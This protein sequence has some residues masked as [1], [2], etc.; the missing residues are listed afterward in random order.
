MTSAHYAARRGSET[1]QLSKRGTAE[2]LLH[3]EDRPTRAARSRR[4]ERL[5]G[6]VA[7][8]APRRPGAPSPARPSRH[9]RA[10]G[11]ASGVAAPFR[12]RPSD[13]GAVASRSGDAGAVRPTRACK[14]PRPRSGR[15]RCGSGVR[16]ER[17]ARRR[18]QPLEAAGSFL[19]PPALG[20]PRLEMPHARECPGGDRGASA[21]VKMKPGAK[22]RTA[23]TSAAVPAMYPPT[24]PKA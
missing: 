24:V 22:L 11:S 3:G 4:C 6:G 7:R 19:V 2:S 8:A 12:S 17:E 15:A 9:P 21:G 23:S 20:L 16:H 14:E 18:Q 13:S 1:M 5:R 10:A